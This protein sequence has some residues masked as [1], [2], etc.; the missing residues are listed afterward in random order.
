MAENSASRENFHI[1]AFF[2]ILILGWILPPMGIPASGMRVMSVFL[3]LLYG[4]SFIGFAWPSL[5]CMVALGWTGYAA[6]MAVLSQAF[7]HPAVIFTTFVLVFTKYCDDSGLN[8]YMARWLISRRCFVGRPWL[9]TSSVL[10]G[11]LIIGFLI[12]GV[13]AVFLI[14]GLL[15]TVFLDIG[16]KKGDSYPAFLLAG[17]CIAGVL[18]FACKPWMGQ[19][20][21]GIEQLTELSHGEF[22]INTLTFIGVTMPVCI[23][24]MLVYVA[25]M[26]WLFRTNVTPLLNLTHDYLGQ[27]R[28]AL[29]LTTQQ[30]VAASFLCLFLAFMILPTVI[31]AGNAVGALLSKINMTVGMTIV[32]GI[33]SFVSIKGKKVFRF[34]D[35]SSG[36]NWNVVLMLAASIP[37]SAAISAPNVGIAPVLTEA[38]SNLSVGGSPVLFVCLLT[39]IA[40]VL[41]QLTHNVTIVLVGVP[42][43]WNIAPVLGINPTG[44]V[45]MLFLGAGAAFATPAASTVG[46]LSF[47]NGEWIGM[48]RA[49][50]AGIAG[51][52]GSMLCILAIGL[53]LVQA[54]FGL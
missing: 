10:V 24:C 19:N 14:S 17:V 13:P 6:P 38:M 25:I 43:I 3:A 51:W 35:C 34:Q 5:I 54:V 26:R 27:I 39:I 15:Y 46:A 44:F 30:K 49:F 7:G 52:I 40:C 22:T 29:S 2:V 23:A 20:I 31:P 12:D 4:W 16:Y 45:M 32:L 50:Q 37:V 33:L 28:S 36:I 1:V 21:L 48:K 9:F 11:T 53:P 47:A 18:S 8:E 41:T 42:L